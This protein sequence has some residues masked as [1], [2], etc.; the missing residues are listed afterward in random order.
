MAKLLLKLVRQQSISVKESD[1]A[2]E[3][4]AKVIYDLSTVEAENFL[5]FNKFTERLDTFYA[6]SFIQLFGKCL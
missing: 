5:N 2:K 1:E 4:F 3:Q 6:E